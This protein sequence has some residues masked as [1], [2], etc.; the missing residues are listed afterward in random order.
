[1]VW[2]LTRG[3]RGITKKFSIG[4][5]SL[6]SGYVYNYEWLRGDGFDPMWNCVLR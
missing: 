1:M 2:C 3:M 5:N 6:M 4:T